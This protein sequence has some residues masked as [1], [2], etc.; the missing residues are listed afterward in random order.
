[1]A[2]FLKFRIFSNFSNKKTIAP[3]KSMPRKFDF[4]EIDPILIIIGLLLGILLTLCVI[5]IIGLFHHVFFHQLGVKL[6]ES[7]LN[8]DELMKCK[9]KFL[10][11]FI[12]LFIL[13]GNHKIC[14]KIFSPKPSVNDRVQFT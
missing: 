6:E 12:L 2:L 14:Q 5:A 9:S 1:M 10:K 13:Q 11:K 3:H 4:L 7:Q 8:G